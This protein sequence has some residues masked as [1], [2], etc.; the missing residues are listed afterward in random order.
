[1]P[2]FRFAPHEVAAILNYLE[3]LQV[4]RQGGP[5]DRAAPAGSDLAETR[6]VR[7]SADEAVKRR[8]P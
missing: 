3:S 2:E 4:R 6:A 8:A 7:A 1:M 5:A